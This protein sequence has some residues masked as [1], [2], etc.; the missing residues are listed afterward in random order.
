MLSKFSHLKKNEGGFTLIELLIVVVIIGILAAVAVPAYS[1]YI[2][3]SRAAEAPQVLMAM[4]EYCESYSNAHD[5]TNPGDTDWVVGFTPD[6]AGNGDYFEYTYNSGNAVVQ[7][8]GL[9]A[10]DDA[11]THTLYYAM[12]GSTGWTAS[13]GIMLGVKPNNP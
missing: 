5:G 1:R 8:D 13:A 9:D 2:T 4:I 7:A 3:V 11:F 6:G 12:T 10:L